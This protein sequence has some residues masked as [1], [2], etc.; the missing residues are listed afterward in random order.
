M[1]AVFQNFPFYLGA[2]FAL[3]AAFAFLIFLRGLLTG[4]PHIITID[5]NEEHQTLYRIRAVWGVVLLVDIFLIWVVI[6]FIE[7]LFGYGQVNTALFPWIVMLWI[8][9]QLLAWWILPKK[10]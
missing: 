2:V 4:F 3:A 5:A 9:W 1:D 6:R 10:V 7:S 8:L